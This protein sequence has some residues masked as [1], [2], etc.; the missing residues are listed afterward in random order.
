MKDKVPKVSKLKD[1]K[2]I[3]LELYCHGNIN[4][5]RQELRQVRERSKVP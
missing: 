5:V 4:R 2:D 3:A 1:F